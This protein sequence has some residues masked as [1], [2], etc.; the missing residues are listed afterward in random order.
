[1]YNSTN[2]IKFEDFK[3]LIKECI[4]QMHLDKFKPDVILGL[5]NNIASL[6]MSRYFECNFL[7]LDLDNFELKDENLKTKFYS[8]LL[9]EN[10]VSEKNILVVLDER[11]IDSSY[12]KFINLLNYTN[13]KYY[14][15]RECKNIKYASL[16]EY[17]DTKSNINYYGALLSEK[18][19]FCFDGWWLN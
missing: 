9:Q 4:R 19:C 16:V 14:N 1:M 11:Q 15:E 3:S 6:L 10:I 5:N 12:R 8:Q 13:N 18:N 17:T 7:L 2:V